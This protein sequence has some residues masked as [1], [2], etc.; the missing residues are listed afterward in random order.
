MCAP[1]TSIRHKNLYAMESY[2]P[3]RIYKTTATDKEYFAAY[4]NLAMHN[5]YLALAYINNICL[6]SSRKPKG[7]DKMV[8]FELFNAL[9]TGTIDEQPVLV[10]NLIKLERKLNRHFP[11]LKWMV[12]DRL[13]SQRVSE[14][15]RIGMDNLALGGEILK[16]LIEMLIQ[17][18]DR[19]THVLS[20]KPQFNPSLVYNLRASFDVSREGIKERY[21]YA[22][23]ELKHLVRFNRTKEYY[24]FNGSK[25]R[26]CRKDYHY[27]F[28]EEGKALSDMGVYY[29]I[30]LFLERKDAQLFL[31][32][33]YGFKDSRSRNHQATFN[34]FSSYSIKLP[35]D[36]IVSDLSEEALALDIISEVRKCPREL[37]G[38]LPKTYQEKFR[39]MGDVDDETE[40]PQQEENEAK[41]DVLLKRYRNRFPELALRFLDGLKLPDG[42]KFF[43]NLRFAIHYGKFYYRVDEKQIALE[44]TKRWLTRDLYAFESMDKV[45]EFK[46]SPEIQALLKKTNDLPENNTTPYIQDREARY[47][48]QS[49]RLLLSLKPKAIDARAIIEEKDGQYKRPSGVDI[50]DA[51]YMSLHD[52]YAFLFCALH[53]GHGNALEKPIENWKKGFLELLNDLENDTLQPLFP[54]IGN[55]RRWTDG[56]SHDLTNFKKKFDER[57]KAVN[58][59]LRQSPYRLELTQIPDSIRDYL[60]GIAPPNRRRKAK[61][62]LTKIIT[63]EEGRLKAYE[64]DIDFRKKSRKKS[65][66]TIQS[67]KIAEHLARD[68]VRMMR[69]ES[70]DKRGKPNSSQYRELQKTFALWGIFEHDMVR[71]L[72]TLQC[73]EKHPFLKRE[74][75]TEGK[76]I[77]AF[78]RRYFTAKKEYLKGLRAQLETLALSD[79]HFLKFKDK[80]NI[81]QIVAELKNKHPLAL[82]RG[83][84]D[85][86]CREIAKKHL[87]LTIDENDDVVYIINQAYPISQEFYD[88]P[89]HYEILDKWLDKRDRRTK[90]NALT[91]QALN[92]EDRKRLLADMKTRLD[93]TDNTVKI[94][95]RGI[96]NLDADKV[97]RMR[98]SC[99]NTEQRLR[100]EQ[101]QDKLL[102]LAA[103]NIVKRKAGL[104]GLETLDLA[105]IS[106]G[107]EGNIFEHCVSYELPYPMK[108]PKL[109]YV[110]YDHQMKLKDYG[111]FKRLLRDRRLPGL[112][113]YHPNGTKIKRNDILAELEQ[114]EKNRLALMK[115][116]IEL[117]KR[118]CQKYEA[119]FKQKQNE[120]DG[121]TVQH[122]PFLD[123]LVEEGAIAPKRRRKMKEMRDKFCH[124]EYPSAKLFKEV[125]KPEN[126]SIAEQLAVEAL[127]LYNL[128][129]LGLK[130]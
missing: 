31:K 6:G 37:F 74:M 67:G 112:L 38:R 22:T 129:S 1:L 125:A 13:Q 126:G 92:L 72:N 66:K 120:D 71:L 113:Q 20:G 43:P 26:R 48:L 50:S 57:K 100:W 82:P 79:L 58:E 98:K 63:E 128:E 19:F 34:C 64:K 28:I 108:K 11:F 4:A 60:M 24:R 53:S 104:K 118:M 51:V 95:K 46:E 111:K 29:L 10:E 70:A 85:Q 107:K 21:G 77:Y 75:L 27:A 3:E 52:L 35:H 15:T 7:E 33:I 101:V 44:T 103:L 55:E 25:I 87:K 102:L 42:K 2:A 56:K 47:A 99:L 80:G 18:R 65:E 17:Y 16:G 73:F 45:L 86:K 12:K 116:V 69:D 84:F 9:E 23:S 89:R 41:D 123:K 130:K 88:Y 97:R 32:K 90:R 83:F 119:H 96:L 110:I 115:A 117:E 127:K 106:P 109:D 124:N 5:A 81:K 30:C 40:R 14:E 76:G 61:E 91:P 54:Q 62:I 39:P 78:F 49:N 121:E 94:I 93:A 8:E 122:D 105:A 36:N 114:Y 68:I 59:K